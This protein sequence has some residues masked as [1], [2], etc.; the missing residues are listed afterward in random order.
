M[1]RGIQ[2][3]TDWRRTN[4][5][6]TFFVV[7]GFCAISVSDEIASNFRMV[8]ECWIW[9]DT[10]RH[11]CNVHR[12]IILAFG[13]SDCEKSRK[14]SCFMVSGL[15]MNLATRIQSDMLIILRSISVWDGIGRLLT[16]SRDAPGIVLVWFVKGKKWSRCPRHEG[17]CG[18]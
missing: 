3:Y 7:Y 5:N 2:T 8:N 13:S 9:K 17:I 11:S 14:M 1:M 4:S 18:E 12:G 10:L 15:R 6:S 16:A